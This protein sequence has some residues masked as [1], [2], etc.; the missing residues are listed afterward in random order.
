MAG[1]GR[2]G[3]VGV[4]PRVLIRQT[5]D[6]IQCLS[7]GDPMRSFQRA[8]AKRGAR[9]ISTE[10]ADVRADTTSRVDGEL[11]CGGSPSVVAGVYDG[12]WLCMATAQ[13]SPPTV[14]TV[15]TVHIQSTAHGATKIIAP[16]ASHP[17][18]IRRCQTR[19]PSAPDGPCSW[20]RD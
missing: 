2:A 6:E 17:S 20:S 1:Q 3:N 9:R 14:H 5:R 8:Q 10:I 19:A 16:P 11:G 15:H 4:R 7:S 13:H 18:Q 12:L